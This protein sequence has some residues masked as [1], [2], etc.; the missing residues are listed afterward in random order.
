MRYTLWM[1]VLVATVGGILISAAA[2]PAV[3]VN[4]ATQQVAGGGVTVTATLIKEDAEGTTIQL[5]LNTHSVSLDAYK[6]ETIA[7]L[8]DDS[9]NLYPL[10]AVEKASGGGHHRQAVLRFAKVNPEAKAIEL[11]VK[12]VAGVK[13]RTFRWGVG[14]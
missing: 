14:E 12:D 11:T 8:R 6:L 5:A 7:L 13:E 2:I 3:A 4:Q 9:R 10:Q 1:T